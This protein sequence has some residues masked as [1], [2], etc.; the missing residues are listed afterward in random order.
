MRDGMSNTA[1]IIEG[2]QIL[3]SYSDAVDT[4]AEHDEFFAG[5]PNDWEVVTKVD[6]EKLDKLGWFK[7]EEFGEGFRI[8]T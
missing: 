1:R 6:L 3:T 7:T 4:A 2:L 8:F 5:F